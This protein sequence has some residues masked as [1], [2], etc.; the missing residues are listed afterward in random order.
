MSME[1]L[2]TLEQIEREKN[3]KKEDLIKMVEAALLA[4]LRK[5]LHT[6][7]NIEVG[8]SRETGEIEAFQK[9][10]VVE[11]VNRP[12][13][14][15]SL[16]DAQQV[17]PK[18]KVGEDVLLAVYTK[19]F[20]RIAAQT[21]KQVIIQRLLETER[22]HLY[23]EYKGKETELINGIV[24]RVSP[25]GIVV[26]LGKTE[27]NLPQREQIRGELY[28]QGERIKVLVLRVNKT[29]KGP[30]VIV[31]RTHPH[32]I[33]KL[34]ELEVPEVYEKIVEIKNVVREPGQRAKI[35][36]SSH[37]EKVDPIGACVG[38]K[39]SRIRNIIDE[40]HGERIDVIVY[41]S[42][43]SNFVAK[44]LSPAK[45][46]SVVLDSSNKRAEV[47]VADDQ[48]SLA[49]GKAGQNV[50]LAAKLT[51]WHIDIKSHSERK[52]M[53][54]QQVAQ[55]EVSARNAGGQKEEDIATP[56]TTDGNAVDD[57]TLLP[58]VGEKLASE[59]KDKGFDTVEKVARAAV[60]D[61][62][63]ISGIGEK[64]AQKILAAAKT[65]SQGGNK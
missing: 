34:F 26:D 42:D 10:K 33:K 15:I 16:E 3:I 50:R 46:E 58:A 40:L 27:A 23:E 55:A 11:E 19:N 2:D 38:I 43:P 65:F 22:E 48:L 56:S 14:E 31:S 36:V 35:A 20:G 32:L 59:L 51:G 18:A 28:R 12:D 60:E 63:Q 1:L 62:L 53:V 54:E 24:Q 49:I 37:N 30:Q 5:H 29:T 64:K 44:S 4:A 41:D 13:I 21:A 6:N 8:I 39:G 17:K 57:L 9:K 45:V 47:T 52:T 25:K 61:L 7:Q